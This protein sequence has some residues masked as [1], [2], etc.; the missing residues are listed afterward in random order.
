MSARELKLEAEVAFLKDQVA[1]LCGATQIIALREAFGLSDKQGR[2]LALLFRSGRT[3]TL[4]AIYGQVFQYANGDGPDSQIVRAVISKLRQRL[5][6]FKA[7]GSILSVY[8]T[9]YRIT[10]E[11]ESWISARL[12]RGASV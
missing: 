7:P 2:I 4:E 5:R 1:E 12:L 8:G 9:G 6:A 11:L 3:V 10:P